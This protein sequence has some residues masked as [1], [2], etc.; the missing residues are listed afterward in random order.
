MSLTT[1]SSVPGVLSQSHVSNQIKPSDTLNTNN[2]P[3]VTSK[4]DITNNQK[5]EENN[6][7]TTNGIDKPNSEENNNAHKQKEESAQK[8]KPQ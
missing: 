6:L 3:D 4:L 8:A 1:K 7:V 5:T 2:D